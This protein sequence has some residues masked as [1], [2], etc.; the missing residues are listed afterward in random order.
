[1]NDAVFSEHPLQSTV[2]S[3]NILIGPSFWVL[4]SADPKYDK[5]C[6]SGMMFFGSYMNFL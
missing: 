4:A 6:G 5:C 3:F 1:M 2:L